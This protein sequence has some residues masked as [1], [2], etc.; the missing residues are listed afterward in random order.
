MTHERLVHL[1]GTS[2]FQSPENQRAEREVANDRREPTIEVP[3]RQMKTVSLN[4]ES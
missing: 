3:I 1:D 2:I 4:A